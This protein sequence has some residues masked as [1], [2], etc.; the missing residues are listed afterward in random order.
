MFRSIKNNPISSKRVAISTLF[1]LRTMVRRSRPLRIASDCSGIVSISHSLNQMGIEHREEWFSDIVPQTLSVHLNN[2]GAPKRCFTD[3]LKRDDSTLPKGIDLYTFGAPCQGWS[4]IGKQLQSHDKRFKVF[5]KCISTCI[6]TM[7]TTFLI[8]NVPIRDEESLA[9]IRRWLSPLRKHYHITDQILNTRHYGLPQNRER[10]YIIGT[11]KSKT[12]KPFIWPEPLSEVSLV[13]YL[14]LKPIGFG[15]HKTSSEQHTKYVRRVI[16]KSAQRVGE[17]F[18]TEPWVCN[19]GGSTTFLTVMRDICPTLTRRSR[20]YVSGGINRRL[21]IH[22][23]AAV[24]GFP[25]RFDWST[26]S[27]SMARSLLGN[28]QSVNVL[29]AIV[30]PLL[31]SVGLLRAAGLRKR[32][33]DNSYRGILFPERCHDV[34]NT[35]AASTVSAA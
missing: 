1:S 25:E 19:S 30:G 28:S 21:T 26:V 27:D 10:W 24:Q 31:R 20:A 5:E 35:Q 11:L 13:E 32:T 8:E 2:G 16:E 23:C 18:Y 29:T 3:V 17:R 9:C 12:R 15:N 34:S 7:P 22:E 4:S 33:S 14:D 6:T